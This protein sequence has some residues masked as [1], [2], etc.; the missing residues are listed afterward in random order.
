[1]VTSR[2]RLAGLDHTHALSLDTLPPADAI[3]LLRQ[4]AGEARLAGQPP[5]LVAELVEL[6]GRL[7]LAVRIAAARLRSHPTW[8]LEHLVRRLRDQQH[9]LVNWR[10]GRVASPRLS[11]CP[12]RTWTRTSAARTAA[13]SAP[14]S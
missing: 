11:I 9:R 1:V 10:P 13:G 6:C 7:P 4:T 8:D 14:R 3:A 5:D 2:R 12:I